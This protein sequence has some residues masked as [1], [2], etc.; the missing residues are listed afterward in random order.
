[1]S[2]VIMD[3]SL[4]KVDEFMHVSRRMRS[5]AL[6]SAVGGMALSIGGMVL[7]AAGWLTPVEGAVAQ[8]CID[9]AAVVNALRAALPPAANVRHVTR[10]AAASLVIWWQSVAIVR[11]ATEMC[12]GH[13]NISPITTLARQRLHRSQRQLAES[14]V[15]FHLPRWFVR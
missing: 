13:P 10:A 11:V 1:A 14:C 8:E 9:V 6:Q 7:A 4:R 3:N 12:S 5:I 2:V 15:A